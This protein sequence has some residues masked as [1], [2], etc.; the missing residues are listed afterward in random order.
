MNTQSSNI[1]KTFLDFFEKKGSQV[2]SSD[3]LVP[4]G[5]KSLLF[6]SAGMV[7]F[8]KHFLGQSNDKF[9]KAT[10]SQKCFRT[11]DIDQVGVTNRHLTFFEMLGNFSF[12][13]YFKEEAIAWA[14]DFLTNVMALPKDKLYITIYKDDNEAGE[15]WKKIIPSSRIIKMGDDTNF[16][17][18]G[19]T[20]PCGPCS[21]ILI[22]LGPEMSCGKPDCGPQCSCNRYLEVWNLVFTQFDRQ[23]DNSL[24]PLPRKNIDTGMGLE[25]LVAV[26]NGKKNVFE[27]D[28]FVPIMQASSELLKVSL[29]DNLSKLRMIADHSRAVTFL[30]SDGILPSNE[31]RGYVLRR[32]LRRALRQ[33]V[34]FGMNEPFLYKLV[35][36][37]HSIMEPAYPE[38]SQRLDNIKS[39]IKVEEEKFLETLN[40]GTEILNNLIADYQ[41]KKIKVING[42]DVFKLYDTYGFPQEL[43]KEIVQEK[44]FNIDEQ[45]FLDEK[46]KAQDKSRSAWTGSGEKDI[47][48][49]S[50][51]HKEFGDTK[52]K[53]YT[54]ES[55]QAKVLAI[56]K[57]NKKVDSISKGET[58]EI[59]LDNTPFYAES[60]GQVADVGTLSNNDDVQITVSEVLKPIGSLFVHKVTVDNG[61]FKTGDIL[62]A[63]INACKRNQIARHHTAT[64]LLQKALR[65]VLGT[66]VAQAGSLVSEDSLRFDFSHFK[67]LTRDELLLVEKTVNSGI[68]KN[69]PVSIDE[70]SM[71]EARK[72]GATAL[73]G[74][75]Y[76]DVVRAVSVGDNS[77]VYSM[78]LCGGTHVKRT[79]DIGA[80]KIIS[81]TSI[82]SGVRRI[83][84]VAGRSAD[85]YFNEI[86]QQFDVLAGKLK[87]SKKS[88]VNSVEKLLE[89]LKQKESE[90]SSIKSK[91]ISSEIDEYIKTAKVI[92]DIKIV[93]FNVKAIDV[94]SLR[95][96]ADKIREKIPS[97]IAIITTETDDKISFV[98]SVTAD[99]VKNG[100]SA[101]K[102]A[103]TFASKIDGS[104]GGKA[105]FAQGGSK[106][107]NK[108]LEI[109]KNTE[110]LAQILK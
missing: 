9:T 53:G 76:G 40:T 21:E 18:M 75:K 86:E 44:G 30:I 71:D 77:E 50:I 5:D 41:N 88:V 4:T 20:G 42:S 98:V 47:T 14:W 26:A 97:S 60:G 89:D 81:E 105:D 23:E 22:D 64:H 3:S 31:G 82:G 62:T 100:Y 69:L 48:F 108:T 54:Q 61:T 85:K 79:G 58:A 33:G 38:L 59:L 17:N 70:I 103:K 25:R 32:I 6:T 74:E 80:F 37:V 19:P 106:N 93:S 24:K 2:V 52:F 109:I 96:M 99:L 87:V 104:G 73:F 49:Y 43:T 55:L 8:K 56:I 27:T 7:Q 68:R 92:N 83:E 45:G 95:D 78:E 51:L 10:T 84:A 13:D 57:D 11:S 66:H 63:T 35:D 65:T 102:I 72:R 1:R 94:K 90:I 110:E 107:I 36:T 34:V 39:M 46:K 16:W 91:L 15:I 12:G 28:L 67:A 101:G 29:N